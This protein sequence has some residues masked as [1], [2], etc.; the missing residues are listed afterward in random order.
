MRI[1]SLGLGAFALF[2]IFTAVLNSL[3][4]ERMSATVTGL[5]VILVVFLCFAQVRGAEFGQDIL[6]RTAV[7]T[8]SALFAATVV[9]GFL[10]WRSTRAL[11]AP[12]VALRVALAMVAAMAVAWVLPEGGRV[13]ALVNSAA[14]SAVYVIVLLISRELSKKDLENVRLVVRRRS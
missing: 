5:A 2:G 13:M 1:L 10:V 12:L 14:V 3:Q 7:A 4:H 9:A 8:S 6:V 11:L